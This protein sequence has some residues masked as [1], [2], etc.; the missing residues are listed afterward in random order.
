MADSWKLKLKQYKEP[1]ADW[2][3]T[4][5]G[6][7]LN[8]EGKVNPMTR[9]RDPDYIRDTNG[10]PTKDTANNGYWKVTAELTGLINPFTVPGTTTVV[11]ETKIE[12]AFEGTEAWGKMMDYNSF[13]KYLAASAAEMIEDR[14]KKIFGVE[15]KLSTI[16]VKGEEEPK[17]KTETVSATPSNTTNVTETRGNTASGTTASGTTASVLDE[18]AY[19]ELTFNVEEEFFF[20]GNIELGKL[21]I[22]GKGI[23]KQEAPEPV[24]E[25]GLDEEYTEEEAQAA[26]EMEAKIEALALFVPPDIK[27]SGSNNTNTADDTGGGNTE[28]ETNTNSTSAPI[29][30][31]NAADFWS[32]LAVC[33]CE[34][35]DTQGRTDVAQSIYNRVLSGMFGGST[36]KSVVTSTWQYEPAFD[37]SNRGQIHSSWKAIKSKET[38]ISAL[39]Y[40]KSY[41]RA[42]AISTLQSTYNA[43]SDSKN[44]KE[45]K[46]YIAQ[47]TDFLGKGLGKSWYHQT[48]GDSP[49]K[50]G[51][52]SS[53]KPVRRNEDDNIFGNVV[54]PGSFKWGRKNKIADV[55]TQ[56]FKDFKKDLFDDVA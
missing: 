10:N 43:I 3:N 6:G 2:Q 35:G 23:I 39:I 26:A 47:R 52:S 45:A 31:G 44:Q 7:Y 9:Y 8:I 37:R 30:T 21:E 41:S 46:S 34:D 38:A 19:G 11:K 1:N 17:P 24:P 53:S 33:A 36:I 18:G 14:Y 48:S 55:P 56:L 28:S 25:E 4:L 49:D 13:S 54:G 15:I 20:K 12:V 51:K 5:S 22:I 27:D 40:T 16:F 32:L 50:S 42:T 29:A